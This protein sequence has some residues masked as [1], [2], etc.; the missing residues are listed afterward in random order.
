MEVEYKFLILQF[1]TPSAGPI[2]EY[3][4]NLKEYIDAIR[5]MTVE[6]EFIEMITSRIMLKMR[7]EERTHLDQNL[8]EINAERKGQNLLEIN[9]ER[10]GEYVT[11]IELIH[12]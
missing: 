5:L 3:A 1:R 2:V 7:F 8:L 11:I 12:S 4:A 10:K 6:L 9:A